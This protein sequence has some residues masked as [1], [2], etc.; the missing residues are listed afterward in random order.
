MKGWVSILLGSAKAGV[1]R[2]ALHE[3]LNFEPCL[4]SSLPAQCGAVGVPYFQIQT[5]TRGVGR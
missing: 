3:T 2:L 4:Y 1:S 5:R